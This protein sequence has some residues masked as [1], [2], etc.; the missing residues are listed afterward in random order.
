[1]NKDKNRFVDVVTLAKKLEVADI[2][3]AIEIATKAK[4]VMKIGIKVWYD[5]EKAVE[6]KALND[7][8]KKE[9]ISWIGVGV[10]SPYTH[11]ADVTITTASDSKNKRRIRVYVR[12]D[13]IAIK[14]T[15]RIRM[16]IGV[17]DNCLYI[18]FNPADQLDGGMLI[19]KNKTGL[20]AQFTIPDNFEIDRK[21]MVGNYNIHQA[22]E[23]LWYVKLSE[24]KEA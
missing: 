1:M 5:W 21:L 23:D 22:A 10:G 6:W 11:S 14:F 20:A 2:D 9:D 16:M 7:Q 17:L 18:T 8:V 24:K 13:S 4:A 12:R 19:E 15:E 3:K